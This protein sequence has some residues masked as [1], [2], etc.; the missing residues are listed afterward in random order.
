MRELYQS[1]ISQSSDVYT[2]M[3]I[4][5]DNQSGKHQRMKNVRS[6]RLEYMRKLRGL[7]RE[8]LATAVGTTATTIYRKERGDRQLRL[9][10]LEDYAKALQCTAEELVSDNANKVQIV[11]YVGAGAKVFPIDDHAQGAGLERVDAPL[12]ISDPSIVGLYV[13]GDSQEPLLEDGWIIFYRKSSDGIP[14]DCIGRLCVVSL[15]SGEMMVK[16]IKRGSS[17]STF[18]LLSK[19][20]DPILD[21]PLLWASRVLDIRPS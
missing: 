3:V 5:P 7:T 8:E 1:G 20:A 14:P 18:H 2:N 15:M 17:P 12:G 13:R 9:E 6:N 21:A 10:E 16:K 19:N 11:G 4:S